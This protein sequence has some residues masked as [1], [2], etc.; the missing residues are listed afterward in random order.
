MNGY[1]VLHP[2]GWGFLRPPSGKRGH[3]EQY[4]AAPVDARQH[5]QNEGA[6]ESPRLPPT[7]GRAKVTTCLP[8]YYR[9]NQW[10]FLKFYEKGFG[11]SQE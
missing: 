11:V 9:W 7:T 6:D 10:F 1:N 2:M 3:P 5:R 4:A 8:D